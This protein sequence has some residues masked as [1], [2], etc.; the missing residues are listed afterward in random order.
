MIRSLVGGKR[1]RAAAPEAERSCARGYA[2]VY[3]S[4]VQFALLGV[5]VGACAAPTSPTPVAVQG[6]YANSLNGQEMLVLDS[7]PV[8]GALSS[9]DVE[10]ARQIMRN[11]EPQDL[12]ARLDARIVHVDELPWLTGSAEGRAFLGMLPQRVLVRGAPAEFCPLALAV[13]APAQR[14]IA[15]VAA[16]A[17]TACLAQAGEGCGC[18]VV[19]AGSV[20]MVPRDEV[21]YA[22]GTS[23]RIRAGALGL[24]GFLVA[25]EEP[26]G[27][28][29]LR[30][31][32]H[33]V[34][35]IER[36][37]GPKV[38]VRLEGAAGVY[39]GT[40]RKVGFRR[41]RLA[42]RIYATNARGDRLSLLIG[43]APDELAE[44]AGAWLAWP[45]DA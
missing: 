5:A 15:E 33:V 40:S 43:F 4:G 44:L 11:L 10:Q 17:L 39:T 38:A 21:T 22:T 37:P 16:E 34:G 20:L 9:D 32:S 29:V 19:A 42:E 36:G 2:P 45:P 41:G 31:V 8:V 35:R 27:T 18:Q 28:V 13:G 25:E 6:S 24:D 12:G 30:D 26:D 7:P 23:A 3:R 1:N 14:P